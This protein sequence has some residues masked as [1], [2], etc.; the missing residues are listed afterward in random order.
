MGRVEGQEVLD[1]LEHEDH[2]DPHHRE[3]HQR[4]GK[5]LPVHLFATVH[6]RR[7]EDPFLDRIDD[8][9]EECPFTGIYL[10]HEPADRD[11]QGSKNH[12]KEDQ[13]DPV[14][15]PQTEDE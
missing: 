2:G 8:G 7:R 12:K 13:L 9:R 10:C 3:Y 6:S 14:R 4:N 15:H 11:D 5:H 1:H